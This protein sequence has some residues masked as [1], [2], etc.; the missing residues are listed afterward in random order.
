MVYQSNHS[1]YSTRSKHTGS[2]ITLAEDISSKTYTRR[3]ERY[4]M[5]LVNRLMF[6]QSILNCTRY[7]T[8]YGNNDS[9]G[10][11]TLHIHIILHSDVSVSVEWLE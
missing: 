11:N 6:T 5:A 7:K 10:K 3:P 2:L 9:N 1:V 8:L 4:Y